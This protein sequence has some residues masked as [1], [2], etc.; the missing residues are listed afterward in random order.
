MNEVVG[1]GTVLAGRYR[2]LEPDTTDLPGSSLWQGNDQILDRPVRV[3]LLHTGDVPQALDAARRAALVIDPRLVRVLDVGMHEDTGYV[4]TEQV[5]GPSL[6]QLAAHGPL[7]ADQ[8]RALVG[9][10]ASA[11]EIARRRGVHHLT[12]RPSAVHVAADGRVL[13]TGLALD[14]AL[15]GL[16]GGDARSTSRTDAVSLVRVLYTALTG[17]WPSGGHLPN[18]PAELPSAPATEQG[19]V[20]PADLVA[21]VP[22]DL[23]TLCAVTLGPHVDGP[24]SPG[25]VVRELEPWGSIRTV[26]LQQAAETLPAQSGW[27][28]VG[29]AVAA[30]AATAAG[31]V[32][33]DYDDGPPTQAFTPPQ[34][35][36]QSV[37]ATFAE[38]ATPGAS[39]P[40]TP[41]PA[42]PTRASAFGPVGGTRP[43]VVPAAQPPAPVIQEPVFQAPAAPPMPPVAV[44][45]PVSASA[46]PAPPTFAPASFAPMGAGPTDDDLHWEDFGAGE[47]AAPARRS[48]PTP[49]VLGAVV[50]VVLIG[51]FLAFRA[52]FAGSEAEDV[53]AAQ[54]TSQAPSST[55]EETTSTPGT[56]PTAPAPTAGGTPVIASIQSID[57][58]DND[59]EHPEAVDLAR[60]GDPSS[61]WYTMTYKRADFGGLKPGVALV[62]SLQEQAT[63]S[64]VK[65]Q[66]NGAGGHVQVRQTDAANPSGGTLLAEG[67]LGPETV[68]TFDQPVDTDTIVL[69]FDGLAT[70][71]D[72]A[73][74]IE[75]A[76]ITLS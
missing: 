70:A 41:P 4:V 17:Q 12:L 40:G 10:V 38:Q 44:P 7:S 57:P 67:A 22:N 69:W 71:P 8:A 34:V 32:E 56:T 35:Q 37:R 24:H 53:P 6:E 58:A 33:P 11:L 64:S 61:V 62:L 51:L 72:G 75:L 19:P 65:L 25:E 36:R 26:G 13:V 59:G 1:R 68:L 50:V 14:G 54:T 45:P 20:P 29:A 46:Q 23:D 3:H 73:Y 21:G 9:E 27:P 39:P 60:D 48:D 18:I 28:I 74:R 55:P 66:I 49:L 31:T 30:G 16:A 43:P 15:L 76:E 63:V 52:L 42:T 5:T 47:P 2:V